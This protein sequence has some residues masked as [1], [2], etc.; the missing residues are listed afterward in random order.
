MSSRAKPLACT[1]M[2]LMICTFITPAF[3][4]E[5]TTSG[6]D[7]SVNA[8]LNA[9]ASTFSVTVPTS[10]PVWVDSSGVLTVSTSAKIVN[11]SSGPVQVYGVEFTGK[12]GWSLA[13]FDADLTTKAVGT[14]E[15]GFYLNGDTTDQHNLNFTQDNWAEISGGSE[16]PLEY[17]ANIAP[18]SE[19]LKEEIAEVIFT[20]GWSLSE[21][22]SP[23]EPLDPSECTP[24]TITI[25][26]KGMIGYSGLQGE[27]LVIPST[28]R[29]EDGVGYV[30]TTIEDR[31]F[32]ACDNLESVTIPDTVTYIG[33]LSF[34][35]CTS[36]KTVNMSNKLEFIGMG[37]FKDCTGLTDITLPSS[38]KNIV[39][40]AFS[41][42]TGF[43]NIVI[44]DSVITIGDYAFD[45]VPQITYSGTA[46][47]SPWGAL[48]VVTK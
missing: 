30:V 4:T 9:E 17:N 39:A 25:D 37:A 20:I 5:I 28:F 29:G 44:P 23:D 18:Q 48:S 43:T 36:L 40:R 8:I 6:G 2:A 19:A 47:G 46:T 10:L 42:C 38:L 45:Q 11:N 33:G 24:F 16:Q 7:S 22:I 27:H 15:V 41:G 31:A 12:N 32:N 13:S 34:G 21:Q 26:N 1:L 14:K 3:A 35:Y